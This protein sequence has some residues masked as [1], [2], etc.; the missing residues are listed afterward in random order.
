[1]KETGTFFT[2]MRMDVLKKEIEPKEDLIMTV[3]L[4]SP[5]GFGEHLKPGALMIIRNGVHEEGRA[6]VLEILGYFDDL[7]ESLN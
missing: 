4:E 7:K 1:M 5:A 3:I 2:I 6:V